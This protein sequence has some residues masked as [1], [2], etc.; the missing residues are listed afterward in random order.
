MGQGWARGVAGQ[1]GE[2]RAKL[3]PQ[4]CTV[5]TYGDQVCQRMHQGMFGSAHFFASCA[6]PQ[7]N[8]NL[9]CHKQQNFG[10]LFTQ[11]NTG[12][13]H[14]PITIYPPCPAHKGTLQVCTA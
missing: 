8:L 7:I 4:H 12:A 5:S 3:V 6:A 14:G 10:T 11:L 2:S 9:D 1:G 13:L